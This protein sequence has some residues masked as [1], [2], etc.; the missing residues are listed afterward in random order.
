MLPIY[1]DLDDVLS[2]TTRT[3]GELLKR[4]YGREIGFEQITSFNLQEA[5]GLT[6]KEYDYF[7]EL[8]HRPEEILRFEPVDGAIEV[9]TNWAARGYEIAIVTGRL[10]STYES[11]LE[12]LLSRKIPY[13]SFIMVDKYSRPG[14]DHRIAISM[15]E[16]SAKKFSLAVEDSLFMAEYIS[17]T[18]D[19]RVA[20]FDRPWNRT[21]SVFD[22]IERCATW[23]RIGLQIS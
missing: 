11:S 8:I 12:W 19:S 21:Q 20:L 23:D 3:Y 10:T 15:D 9:L 13:D 1:V 22:K 6:P 18:L 4:E 2:E 14:T 7:F 16:L 5:F 17:R